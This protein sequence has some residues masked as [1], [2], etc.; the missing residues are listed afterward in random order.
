MSEGIDINESPRIRRASNRIGM[1][2]LDEEDGWV[3]LS[4]GAYTCRGSTSEIEEEIDE[5]DI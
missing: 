1:R 4:H 2:E 5:T 3:F